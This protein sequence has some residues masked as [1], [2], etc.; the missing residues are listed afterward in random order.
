MEKDAVYA[1][2][3]IP[4]W[5][6]YLTLRLVKSFINAQIRLIVRRCVLVNHEEK[7]VLQVQHFATEKDVQIVRRIWKKT[8][9]PFVGLFGLPMM[10]Q[11]KSILEKYWELSEKVVLASLH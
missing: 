4:I 2:V 1:A 3:P 10:F 9:V 11:R 6:S 8:A 5:T 7:P